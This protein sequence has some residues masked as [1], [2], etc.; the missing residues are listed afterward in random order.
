MSI[1]PVYKN[2]YLCF[3]KINEEECFLSEKNVGTQF[4][5][6]Q[7]HKG[8]WSYTAED[9]SEEKLKSKA[10]KLSAYNI[11]G[12]MDFV[13]K[14]NQFSLPREWNDGNW[15][16]VEKCIRLFKENSPKIERVYVPMDTS[17][18]PVSIRSRL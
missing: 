7:S 17:L 3:L 1:A 15:I 4:V 13:T 12:S 9:P 14:S 6:T 8:D 11:D 16:A 10:L 2:T 5:R 18:C